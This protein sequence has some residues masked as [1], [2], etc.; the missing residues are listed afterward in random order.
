V[1][2]DGTQVDS[3]PD[4]DT[5]DQNPW[6]VWRGRIKAAQRRRDDKLPERQFNVDARK[7]TTKR[8]STSTNNDRLSLR[9]HSVSVNQDWPITK[10][11]IAQ[12]YSQ[13]P[14][15]RLT[16]RDDMFAPAVIPFGQL[17]NDTITDVSLGTTVE[18]ILADVV[19]AAGVGAV[20]VSC[21]SL[22]QMRDV[23][24]MDPATVPPEL[25]ASIP[26]TPVETVVSRQYLAQRISPADLLV[27]DDF[28]GSNYDQA[29]WLGE[30]GR[31]T[32]TQAVSN[33][34]LT[35][36]QKEKAVGRDN[37]GGQGT[38]T[39]NTDGTMF[40]DT[41]VVNYTQIFYWRHFYHPEEMSFQA[42]Q[43]IV[44]VDGIDD[45]VVNEPYTAQKPGPNGKMF[46]V[47][48]LPIR[49]LTL[50]YISDD[51]LPP[52]DSSVIRF[53]VSEL[54]ASRDAMVQQ[55]KHSIPI[56][57]G[58]RNRISEA[59][60]SLID[61]GDYQG[62]IWTNGPGDRAV[63]EV[64]RASHAA[65]RYEFDSVI[66]NDITEITQVGNNQAGAFAQGK[67]SAREAGIVEANFQRR[68]GQEQDKVTRFVVGI[69]EVLAGH[70]AIYGALQ[71]PGIDP[72]M[73]A[74]GF[75]YSVRLDSTVRQDA[76]Q[77]IDQLERVINFLAQS[78]YANVKPIVQEYVELNG[79][80]ASKVVVDPQ[81][82]PPEPVKI[83]VSD[84][85]SLRDPV[86]LAEL[87]R[88]QQLPVPEDVQA[89][90]AFLDALA[91]MGIG[92]APLPVG[93][94]STPG[95]GP[96]APPQDAMSPGMANPDWQAAP[97]MDK[98]D[99]DGGGVSGRSG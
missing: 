93:A 9:Q 34:G 80:D 77:R 22:T 57:W 46:G 41:D 89:A 48:N 12:L 37:R 62:F 44:F 14:E 18:E 55:R 11:K 84:V 68:V 91:Q 35:P 66:K 3:T 74:T 98:R 20:L 42:I 69:A 85:V 99:Q 27:P 25:Q 87:A 56:R 71:I 90:K 65:E 60:K 61:R 38:H 88:T 32:W 36:D 6:D 13:T 92:L 95:A 28:T 54:E 59:T 73:L 45:P 81:P 16:P 31:M 2:G 19:N 43:R 58:D 82:K 63:G 75:S 79:I 47:V 97:R 30:D 83:S 67:R 15:I 76:Q 40:S 4:T 21:E 51:N 96:T 5:P 24:V 64:A 29:R 49:V 1:A 94:G 39:L 10:A 50:T 70:L 52:S 17:L 26:T 7:G 78:P 86:M 23:P 53:Q 33:L 8:T 72:L